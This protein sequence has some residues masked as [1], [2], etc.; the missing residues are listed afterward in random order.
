M[1]K[2]AFIIKNIL[3]FWWWQDIEKSNIFIRLMNLGMASFLSFCLLAWMYG[4]SFNIIL[5]S[6]ISIYGVLCFISF[7]PVSYLFDE[8]DKAKGSTFYIFQNISVFFSII[9]LVVYILKN[10]DRVK[11]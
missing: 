7:W 11:S 6:F 1:K 9:I 2:L 8:K 3:K 10:Y 4:E 5:R